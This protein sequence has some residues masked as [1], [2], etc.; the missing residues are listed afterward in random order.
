MSFFNKIFSGRKKSPSPKP[1]SPKDEEKKSTGRKSKTEVLMDVPIIRKPQSAKSQDSSHKP[2]F[3]KLVH[4][5][6]DTLH[7]RLR[8]SEGPQTIPVMVNVGAKDADLGKNRVG[9]DVVMIIDISGSMGGQ[10]IKLVVETLLFIIDQM[11]EMDRLSLIAFDNKSEILAGLTPMTEQAK[12]TFKK[13]VLTHIKARGDTDIR[14][15]L[16]D[17]YKVLLNRKEVNDVTAV[18]LLSDGQ[19]TCGNSQ[20]DIRKALV[21]QD[22][23]MAKKGMDYK[24]HSFGYGEGHDEKVLA[25]IANHKEGNFYYIKSVQSV[26]ECFIDCMGYLMSVFGSQAEVTV[27]VNGKARIVRRLGTNWVDDNNAAKATL[28]VGNLAVGKER[29]FILELEVPATVGEAGVHVCSG[30]L[31]YIAEGQNF[32]LE[33]SLKPAVGVDGD[34]GPKNNK[35]EANFVRLEAAEALQQA[36]EKVKSGQVHLAKASIAQYKAKL[37]SRGVEEEEQERIDCLLNDDVIEN[38]KDLLENKDILAQEAYRP[39]K[40]CYS[41]MNQ[42]Q[43]RFMSMKAKK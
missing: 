15:G 16:E 10:K 30:I 42:G 5:Q 22:K 11:Q 6:L 35:V 3:S 23:A 20:E 21:N 26:D 1:D 2:D 37:R 8:S 41:A 39:G 34:I 27:Y 9:L 24:I 36:E 17:G 29:N 40:A 13:K 31:N 7:P 43:A 14:K 38:A 33:A 18:F 25:M 4:F 32:M 12:E 19:D 28:K